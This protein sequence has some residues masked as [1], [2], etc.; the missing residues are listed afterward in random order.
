MNAIRSKRFGI[1]NT[2]AALFALA[3]LSAV[4]LASLAD[5]ST[6]VRVLIPQELRT[7]T[8]YTTAASNGF[9]YVTVPGIRALNPSRNEAQTYAATDFHLLVDDAT[10]YPVARPKLSSI[11]FTTMSIAAPREVTNVTVSFLIP[12][13]V[14]TASLEFIPHWHADDGATINFCCAF[15]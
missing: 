3:L 2:P 15:Q 8:A 1:V 7:D 13:H 6:P 11:D 4:P 5:Q 10:Y 14:E 12:E 9:K